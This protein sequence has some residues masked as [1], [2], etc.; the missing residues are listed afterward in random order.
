MSFLVSE[1]SASFDA[2]GKC[3]KEVLTGAVGLRMRL[4][5]SLAHAKSQT[6]FC[7]LSSRN[8]I[9]KMNETTNI[10]ALETSLK[11]TQDLIDTVHRKYKKF[12]DVEHS[13][14]VAALVHLVGKELNLIV[15][16]RKSTVE[17]N[18]ILREKIHA[19][20][21]ETSKLEVA[22]ADAN[23]QRRTALDAEKEFK[24]NASR[25]AIGD[26]VQQTV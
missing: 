12:P 1:R 26:E 3:S 24:K 16:E 13:N 2:L 11:E 17:L 19:L 8:I 7:C 9:I 23:N 21:N 20:E 5:P 10:K 22:I 15:K 4:A 6:L 18:R 25:V 14:T